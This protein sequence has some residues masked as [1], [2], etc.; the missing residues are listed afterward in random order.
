MFVSGLYP[1][2]V[3]VPPARPMTIRDLLTHTS[4]LTYGSVEGTN[5]D[6]AYSALGVWDPNKAG[7]TLQNM[8]DILAELPREY[9]W[10]GAASTAFWVDPREEELLSFL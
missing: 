2:F 6:A 8:V 3:T 7:Y 5:V 4:G 1:R 9:A 10:G